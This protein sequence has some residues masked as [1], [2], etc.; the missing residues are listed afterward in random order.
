MK[1]SHGSET[2]R[3]VDD[4]RGLSLH[5]VLWTRMNLYHLNETKKLD[6]SLI[7]ESGKQVPL[8]IYRLFESLAAF[9]L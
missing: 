5:N 6:L 3:S 7:E 2:N 9:L 4:M 1:E 8:Y